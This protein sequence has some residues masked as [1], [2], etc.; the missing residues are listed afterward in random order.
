[1]QRA[2]YHRH[3]A[4]ADLHRCVVIRRRCR[5]SSDRILCCMHQP[6]REGLPTARSRSCWH[7]ISKHGRAGATLPMSN[8]I[9]TLCAHLD[10]QFRT[11]PVQ[12]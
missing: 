7:N 3:P 12:L 5:S 2:R 1:M 9:F 11:V 8:C 6:K 4:V 10:A